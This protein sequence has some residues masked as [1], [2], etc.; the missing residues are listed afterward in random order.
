MMVISFVFCS[1]IA[2]YLREFKSKAGERGGMGAN[3]RRVRGP[4]C[5]ITCLGS[6]PVSRQP[7]LN[8]GNINSAYLF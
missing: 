6:D 4:S 2:N 5:V 8:E 3:V 1:R 7:C